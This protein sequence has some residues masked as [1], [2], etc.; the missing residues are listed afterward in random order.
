MKCKKCKGKGISKPIRVE[1]C[2]IFKIIY[3]I[4]CEPCKT[5]GNVK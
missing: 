3:C 5:T 1:D 4:P 2:G